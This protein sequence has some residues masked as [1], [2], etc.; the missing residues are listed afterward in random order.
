VR[1]SAC[2]SAVFEVMALPTDPHNIQP[3]RLL[4]TVAVMCFYSLEPSTLEAI[5]GFR[6]SA[7]L[8]GAPHR[9]MRSIRRTSPF[10]GPSPFFA[11]LIAATVAIAPSSRRVAGE[12]SSVSV[13]RMKTIKPECLGWHDLA[14]RRASPISQ[15]RGCL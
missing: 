10:V 12:A 15:G 6:E 7:T 14:A 1:Q 2:A 9:L 13:S 11:V 4:I 8:D 5:G 3:M